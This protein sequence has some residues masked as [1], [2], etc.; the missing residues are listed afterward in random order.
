MHRTVLILLLWLAGIGLVHGET[1]LQWTGEQ[2][3]GKEL[4]CR[5]KGKIQEIDGKK[6]LVAAEGYDFAA[7]FLPA[8]DAGIKLTCIGLSQP[9][10]VNASIGAILFRWENNAWKQ[11][12]NL[13]W[14][15][16]LPFKTARDVVF[17]ARRDELGAGS[18][19]RM[20]ILYRNSGIPVLNEIRLESLSEDDP[21]FDATRKN[22][23]IK[24]APPQPRT[25]EYESGKGDTLTLTYF[26]VGVYLYGDNLTSLEEA[27]RVFAEM[28]EA[29]INSVHFAG[30]VG[31]HPSE[32]QHVLK[33]AELAKEYGLKLWV[34]M[35]D[36]YY[37]NDGSKALS[38]MKLNSGMEYVTR[39][40]VPR[41]K[42]HLP[43]Y[44]SDTAVY[45]WLPAE[46]NA[47]SSVGPL[48]EYRRQIWNILPEQRIFEL[49]TD[50]R[51]LQTIKPPW[52]NIAG[53][54]RYPFMYSARGAASRLWLP[55]DGLKWYAG[56]IRPFLNQAQKMGLPMIAV[57]QGSQI[58]SFYPPEEMCP[59]ATEPEFL[60]KFRIETAPGM[61]YYPQ[62][63]KFGRWSM[64]CPCPNGIRAQSWTAVAEG[65]RGILIYAYSPM[66]RRR[67]LARAA[68]QIASGGRV[69]TV[70]L[71]S[72]SPG[73]TDMKRTFAEL[74]PWGRL[75]LSL[76]KLPEMEIQ[77]KDK[78]IIGNTFRDAHG[79]R[80]AI[81]ANT[82]LMLPG[83]QP[84]T[85]DA[86]GELVNMIPAPPTTVALEARVPIYDL[87]SGQ[88]VSSLTLEPG[89]GRILLLG[90]NESPASVRDAYRP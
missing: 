26:P 8:S 15:R 89:Q 33:A 45:A 59:G 32:P 74:K 38:G 77:F 7:I 72:D 82:R 71:C 2:P 24:A 27:R 50:L 20:I 57:I 29:G 18:G 80:F 40:A 3:P 49:F 81:L 36:V 51:T 1:L 11:V 12:K 62:F 17:T 37:R 5:G 75:L 64:Y 9:A 28:R 46:E 86:N 53:I 88:A 63:N 47:P 55:D 66:S 87:E 21:A 90:G 78:A 61:K 22:A 31:P 6:H 25:Y 42:Q 10:Q 84:P 39:Y 54:D 56:A 73:W 41:L 58:Y 67:Q 68:E 19:R 14:K 52:P 79:R 69:N 43:S 60:A 76:E 4:V 83:K 35:N 30:T 70:S 44:R 13:G 34:Q 23:E 85:V 65:A 16:M 48:A